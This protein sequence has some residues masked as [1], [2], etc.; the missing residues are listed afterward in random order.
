MVHLEAAN[1]ELSRLFDVG[2]LMWKR[3]SHVPGLKIS[4]ATQSISGWY[5]DQSIT[6]TGFKKWFVLN[7]FC[8]GCNFENVDGRLRAVGAG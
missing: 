1:R 4:T 7:I 5:I 2:T 6:S 3:S 8:Y